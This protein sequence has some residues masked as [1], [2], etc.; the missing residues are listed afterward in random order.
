[1]KLLRLLPFV[2]ILLSCAGQL[3]AEHLPGGSLTYTCLGGNFFEIKLSVM[4]ECSGSAIA[5][6]TLYFQNNCGVVFDIQNIEYSS[7]Q[8]IS[9]LC[10]EQSGNSTCDNGPLPGFEIYHFTREVYLS[11]CDGWHI[12]WQTC[13]RQSSV[14]VQSNPGLYLEMWIY[15]VTAPCSTSPVFTNNTVPHVCVG[16]PVSFDAGATDA[17]GHTLVHS[18]IDARFASPFPVSVN[19]VFPNY[20][21]EPVPGMTLSPTGQLDFTPTEQGYIV[22]AVQVEEFNADGQL[23]GMVMRDF[24]FI[25]YPCSNSPPDPGSGLITATTG[26]ASI[27]G[28]RTFS[29]CNGGQACA[30]IEFTD[31]DASQSIIGVAGNLMDVLPGAVTTITGTDPATLQ[32][33]WDEVDLPT[34][35]R[36]FA[37]TASDDHCPIT[38]LTSYMYTVH[39]IEPSSTG[40]NGSA[41]ACALT[42]PFALIDSLQGTPPAGGQ[43]T[44]PQGAPHSGW[45]SNQTDGPG[46]YTYSAGAGE[47][48]AVLELVISFLP[49]SD[50]LCIIS[51]MDE[52]MHERVILH[53]NPTTGAIHLDDAGGH[54]LVIDR[55]GRIVQQFQPA[56]HRQRIDLNDELPD[57]PYLLRSVSGSRIRSATIMLQR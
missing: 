1:M 50:P 47:C 45:F 15:N 18:L 33:C 13:C 43:W 12:Y 56:P 35:S 4:R 3:R 8:N 31:P 24:P 5:P 55:L 26:G 38:G 22:V 23:T 30:L 17:D 39:V 16:Q 27:L 6:Q 2:S 9:Q 49:E 32:I 44:D 14:N 28:P 25:A 7:M 20:G 34:G 42:L 52:R 46:T 41:T 53:P 54:I 40:E 51:S 29:L 57:G 37:L 19:Y 36:Q 21:G 10:P 11:P 48:E